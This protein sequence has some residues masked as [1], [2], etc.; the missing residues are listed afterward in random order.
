MLPINTF[1]RI[2]RVHLLEVLLRY[3]QIALHCRRSSSSSRI[4]ITI[5]MDSESPADYSW[6][7]EKVQRKENDGQFN[8]H[9]ILLILQQVLTLLMRCYRVLM[10]TPVEYLLLTLKNPSSLNWENKSIQVIRYCHWWAQ[11]QTLD[12]IQWGTLSYSYLYCS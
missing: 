12:T 2:Y 3:L 4:T 5:S 11:F 7:A 10:L 8:C 1:H 6:W 9:F